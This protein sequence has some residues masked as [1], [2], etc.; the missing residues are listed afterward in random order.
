MSSL[1][2]S[3]KAISAYSI[4]DHCKHEFGEVI[5][6]MPVYRVLD[7]QTRL[8]QAKQRWG[9]DTYYSIMCL[10]HASNEYEYEEVG[11]AKTAEAMIRNIK[12]YD[13]YPEFT[14]QVH[15]YPHK[16]FCRCAAIYSLNFN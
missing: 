1:S 16:N 6:A 10:A 5:P 4:V 7:N 8:V 9:F 12:S 2:C 11:L 15:H 3:D 13:Y 14:L